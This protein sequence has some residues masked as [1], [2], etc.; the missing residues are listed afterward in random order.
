MFNNKLKPFFSEFFIVD[1]Q[2]EEV[3]KKDEESWVKHWS[4]IPAGTGF[5]YGE[6]LAGLSVTAAF[7]MQNSSSQ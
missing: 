7:S 2:I 5:G 3:K 4:L 6:A 1:L